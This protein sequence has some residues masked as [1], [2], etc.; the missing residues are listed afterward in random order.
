MNTILWIAQLGLAAIFFYAG[1]KNLLAFQKHDLRAAAGPSFQWIGVS[2]P[3]ACA[4]GF[5][6]ILGAVGLVVPLG[7]QDPYILA[8]LSA[9]GLELLLI[10]ACIYHARRNEHT[11]PLVGLFFL[12]VFVIVGRM[13]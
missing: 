6:E 10:A 3:T 11:S 5:A 1:I 4:I 13:H 8:Q 9:G 7:S 2:A 12:A